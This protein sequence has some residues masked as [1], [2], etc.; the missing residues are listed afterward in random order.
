MKHFLAILL[1]LILS[2]A[3]VAD[4]ILD[5][6]KSE[7]EWLET[8]NA[9]VNAQEALKKGDIRLWAIQGFTIYIPGAEEYKDLKQIEE[10]Y[11][12]RIIKGTSDAVYGKEHLRLIRL[13]EEYAK[14][15]NE[16]VISIQK[17]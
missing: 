13:A 15:Y 16:Y 7:M 12:Y 5:E 1:I 3:A 2:K 4:E 11:G 14:K 10:I 6:I 8:A 17:Q 9:T